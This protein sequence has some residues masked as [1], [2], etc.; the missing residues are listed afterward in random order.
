MTI[1]RQNRTFILNNLEKKVFLTGNHLY[2]NPKTQSKKHLYNNPKNQSYHFYKM[3]AP[4]NNIY[5][6]A[7]TE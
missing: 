7:A 3:I 1:L 2:N 4:S 5:Q 6:A